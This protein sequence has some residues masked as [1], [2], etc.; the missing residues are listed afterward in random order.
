MGIF[1]ELFCWWSGNSLGMRWTLSRSKAEQ[2]G[3]D[4]FGNTYW[5]APETMKG[6]GERRYVIYGGEADTSTIPPEWHAW[7]HHVVD[8]PPS[9]SDPAPREW[10]KPHRPNMTGSADAYR[11]SGSTLADG[12]RP[13][14]T[15]DYEAWTPR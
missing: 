3:K 2:V 10:Q 9:A 5:R 1:K 7:I 14:A 13:K 15:G 8:T 6:Y 11:P 12:Q 4:G